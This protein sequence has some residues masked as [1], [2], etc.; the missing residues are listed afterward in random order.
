VMFLNTLFIPAPDDQLTISGLPG[1]ALNS[2]K[3]AVIAARNQALPPAQAALNQELLKARTR[4]DDGLGSFDPSASASFRAGTSEDPGASASGA[5]AITPDGVVVRGDIGGSARTAPVVKIEE[6]D[7]G[8]AFT[9]LESWIPGGGIAR[10]TWS[11]VEYTGP[12]I[13]S[14]VTKT[15]TDEHRFIF[16]K[17]A[18]ITEL[19]SICLRIEG[20]QTLADGGVVSAA[21]GTTCQVP[22]FGQILEVPSWL[23]AV[24]VPIWLPD[25]PAGAVLKETLAGHVSIQADTPAGDGPTHNSLVYF[26][27]WR[28]DKPLSALGEALGRMRRKGFSLVVIV[29]VPAEAFDGQ[30]REVEAKLD[31]FAERFP[32]TLLLTADHEDGWTRTFGASKKPA[33]Y[34]INARREFVWK[35]EGAVDP[36]VLAA[37]LDE[38]LVPAPAPRS[39]A[40]R[41]AVSPG[42]RAPDVSFDDRGR[43]FQLHRLRGREVLLNFWQS[44]SA[45]CIKELRRLQELQKQGSGRAPF[46]VAFHGGKE[47]KIVDEIRKQH[48]LSFPL[49]HDAEQ[50]I[51]RRYGVRCW[52]TT[53]SVGADG[54]VGHV[55]FGVAH[56]HAPPTE[57]KVAGS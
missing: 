41:L 37:A 20:T 13:F 43:S 42:D 23:E 18:G 40:L 44:W 50:V 36:K 35:H 29:V 53:V 46:I 8:H 55:Q 22:D 31:S 39:R 21:G 26:A 6:T 14:G 5:I 45:P 1:A 9:A 16:P 57:R 24:T 10:L 7:Q 19:S 2:V 28:A 38:R 33:S 51:A 54:L 49:V 56:D 27:D 12:T 25:S 30:R 47:G 11:W 4:F 48:E 32:A 52:P 34:L 15:A 3:L 17:P